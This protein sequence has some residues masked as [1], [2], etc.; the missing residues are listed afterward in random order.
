MSKRW[1]L[2]TGASSGIGHE[3]ALQLANKG[4]SLILTARRLSLLEQLSTSITKSSHVDVKIIA[5]DLLDHKSM[6]ALVQTIKDEDIRLD[7]LFNNAGFGDYGAF[8]DA[9]IEKTTDMIILNVLRL[10]QLTHALLPY[11]NQKS[12]ICN[13][14]SLASFVP[15]PYMSVYYATKNYVLAFSQALQ[16]ELKSSKIE[17]STFCPGPI[18]TEFNQVANAQ[19]GKK[20]KTTMK[21]LGAQS[22]NEAV[23]ALV[24]GLEKRKP[25]IYSRSSHAILVFLVR[26]VPHR[27]IGRIIAYIQN[28]RFSK[29]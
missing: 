4:Y 17:V 11:M 25:I 28:K 12:Q 10:T 14:G 13:V 29:E 1:A 26:L 15:G 20:H 19:K 7:L 16:E 21:M 23:K 8:Q 18:A 6:E 22:V 9:D 5:V 24:R 3:L 27:H 2:I